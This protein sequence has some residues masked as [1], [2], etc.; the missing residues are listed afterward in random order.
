MSETENPSQ[1]SDNLTKEE[2]VAK[3]CQTLIERR[4]SRNLT[5]EKLSQILKIRLP[6]LQAIEKGQ[7]SE[8][9]GEVYVRGFIRRYATYLGLDGD[10]LIKPHV[11]ISDAL[12]KVPGV[13]HIPPPPALEFPKK[14]VFWFGGVVLVLFG[15][16]KL[17]NTDKV[18]SRPEP[19]NTLI[20]S[21]APIEVSSEVDKTVKT[22]SSPTK[23]HVEHQLEVFSPFPLWVR[24]AA[25]DKTFEGFIPQSSTWNWKGAGKFQVRVGHTREVFMTFDGQSVPLTESQRII[26]LPHEN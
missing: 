7:W 18:V 14:H 24:V 4:E 13:G 17:F 6:Y 16:I 11:A 26:D 19:K 8:L 3:I 15:L 23:N 9:P 12:P 20:A 10:K 25:Q 22:E 2:I 1:N 5:L 21:S